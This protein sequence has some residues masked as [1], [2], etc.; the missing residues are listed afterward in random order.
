MRTFLMVLSLCWLGQAQ[1]SAQYSRR[2]FINE[3]LASNITTNADIVDFDDFSDWVELYNAGDAEVNLAGYFITD[4]PENPTKWR[5]PGGTKI[6]AKGFLLVWADGYDQIPGKVLQRSYYPFDTYTTRYCHLNFKLDR[7]GEFIGLLSPDTVLV[8]SV[9]YGV[10][11]QDVSVGRQPDG[12]VQWF[13]FGE[14]TPASANTT[15]GALSLE[16]VSEPGIPAASGF[17]HGSQSVSILGGPGTAE[18][19]YTLDGSRPASTSLLY[20]APLS[21]G[22]STVVNARAFAPGKLPSTVINRTIFLDESPTLPVISLSTPPDLLWDPIVGIYKN[23]YKSRE[24]PVHVEFFTEE[25]QAGFTLNASLALS[26]QASLLYPQKS[27]TI[28]ADNRFGTDAIPYQVFPERKLESYV[29]LYLRNAGVPDNRSTFF[30]DALI[31]SLALNRMELDCQAYRP[32]VV[33][34]N[35][36]YWGIYN[37]REKT[38]RFY[39]SA[40]HNVNPD[41][42]DMLEYETDVTPTVMEGNA[43]DYDAFYGFV[44]LTDLSLTENYRR[45][46]Q[47]MD[48]DEYINYQILEIY[49]DNVF[50]ADENVRMWRERKPWGKWRWILQDTDFGFGMPNV[51]SRGVSNNTLRFATSSNAG[52]RYVPPL[53]STLLFRKLLENPGFRT[54]FIQR[55]ATCLNTLY[56]PDT[57]VALIDRFAGRLSPEMPRHI[58]RW[59]NGE[60]YFGDPIP[61]MATWLSN[62]NVLRSFARNRPAYQRAHLVDY[63]GLAGLTTVA[64]AMNGRGMGRVRINGIAEVL[65]N[66]THTYFK[67]IPTNLEAVPEVGYRFVRW[68]DGTDANPKTLL[69]TLDSVS[70]TAHF[71]AV[72]VDSIP[73]RITRDTTLTSQYSPYYARSDVSV[74]SAVTLRLTE[75]VTIL[76]PQGASLVVRGRLLVDGSEANPVKI[77]PNENASAWGALCFVNASDSSIVSFMQ[78]VGATKGPDFSRDRGAISGYNSRISLQHVSVEDV[79][80]PLF[81]RFGSITVRQCRFQ[82]TYAGDLINIKSAVFAATEECVLTGG[83]GYDSDG[84]DYDDVHAGV[85]RNNWIA[86]IHG[87]NSDAIDLGEGAVDILVEGNTIANINDKGVSVGQGSTTVIRRNVIANC[88]MGVAVKDFDSYARVEQNTFYGN[89]VAVAC[90][91]KN[92]GNGGGR[93]SVVNSILANSTGSSLL[94]DGLSQLTISYSISN[95]DSLPGL[96]NLKADPRFLNNL[97]ISSGS[98]A[99]DFGSP[100]LPYDPDGSLADAGAFPFDTLRQRTLIIDEIH[101]HPV[102]GSSFEFVELFNPGPRALNL[103][104]FRLEGSVSCQ[105]GNVTMEKGEYLVVAGNSATYAGKGYQVVQWSSGNLPDGTGSLWLKDQQGGLVDVVQYGNQTLWPAEADGLG[106]SLELRQ[107]NLENLVSSSWSSS[108][109]QGGTP[110]RSR[111]SGLLAGLYINEFMADN[112]AIVADEQGEFD[113][114][115]ELYNANSTAVDVGGLFVTDNLKTPDKYMIPTNSPQETTIPAKG[116]V[117]LWAD[118]QVGQGVRHLSIKLDKAGEQIG[119]ARSVDGGLVYVDSLSFAAQQ[120]NSSYGRSVDGGV[121]WRAFSVPTPGARNSTTG[122]AAEGPVPLTFALEQNY[123]NPF[124]PATRI[125]FQIPEVGRIKLAVYD[126]LGR[127]VA[128][129]VDER[130]NAGRHEV[131][132][133]ASA[134]PTGMYIC[135]MIAGNSVAVR[136]LLLIR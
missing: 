69:T 85:I 42:V 14:P 8:D 88:G 117:V 32:A 71:E 100:L 121:Q 35:A 91:E 9:S 122:V 131:T 11:Q 51:R 4:H 107:L 1:L 46:E 128:V 132:W 31:H 21:V 24:I 103:S 66:C 3:F 79:Q 62:V 18:L 36:Q 84:I 20:T 25:S 45:A 19:R 81:V 95:V 108:Y 110:G 94:V 49:A 53:W 7:A 65:E 106:P 89:G 59:K 124:N 98:P 109:P 6:P 93:A 17:Y 82:T 134:F 56:H 126:L 33:F 78:I 86:G 23:N 60:P 77:A 10:Q 99:I 41:D 104:G 43:D 2:I 92:L 54:N 116:F 115:I 38:D 70:V 118:G 114:W 75:G 72:T 136:K 120:T 68:E 28:A 26:G 102:E 48:I 112:D 127:E 97:Y 16:Y 47:W 15:P 50:W 52:D 67:G 27:F 80:M 125:R 113:D 130:K 29:S 64:V 12:S 111:S 133:D 135:R 83:E 73:S 123:P 90:Y 96:H 101:Y 22:T 34:L 74:D 30:R 5:F 37:I 58:E 76:M 119:L 13:S 55:F 63:F 40:L 87:F 129:L 105:F 39:I 44:A 61:D 57:V